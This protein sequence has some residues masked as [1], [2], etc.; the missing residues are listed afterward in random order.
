MKMRMEMD[1]RMSCVSRGEESVR[2]LHL[3][4]RALH[5]KHKDS[6]DSYQQ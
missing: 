5:R 1:S 2:N 4:P 6:D 3:A